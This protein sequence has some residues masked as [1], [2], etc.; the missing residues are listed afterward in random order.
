MDDILVKPFKKDD[1]AA[2]LAEYLPEAGTR[3][4]SPAP[5][6]QA[7]APETRK[8][9]HAASAR[10]KIEEAE[11]SNPRADI[12]VF[13]WAGVLDTFLGQK[14]TVASLLSRFIAKVADQLVELGDAVAAK[15]S[16]KFREVSHSIKGASWNLSARRLGDAALVGE[17]AGREGDLEAAAAALTAIQAAY[18]DFV[19]AASPFAKA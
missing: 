2:L 3:G 1:L 11:S 19:I 7:T 5:Q 10:A 18:A 13:D 4:A 15:D 17:N 12:A 6:T 9:D 14:E 16:T 8:D